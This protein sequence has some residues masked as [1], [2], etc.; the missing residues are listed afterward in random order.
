MLDKDTLR[1]FAPQERDEC[2]S[3]L[4]ILRLDIALNFDEGVFTRDRAAWIN[5]LPFETPERAI[6]QHFL[7]VSNQRI[8]KSMLKLRARGPRRRSLR[9]DVTPDTK[10]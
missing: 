8:A 10:Q 6:P 4:A 3:Q 9:D 7:L 1:R 2:F 5:N